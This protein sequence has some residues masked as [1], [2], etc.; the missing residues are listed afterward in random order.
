MIQK[1]VQLEYTSF[2]NHYNRNRLFKFSAYRVFVKGFIMTLPLF[3]L[4]ISTPVGGVTLDR[5]FLFSS[6]LLMILSAFNTSVKRN[7]ISFTLFVLLMFVMINRLF[8]ISVLTPKFLLFIT[9]ILSF[10]VTFKA[11]LKGIDLGRAINISF[12]IFSSISIYSLWHFFTAGY[13]PS[14]FAFLDSISFI[15]PVNYDHMET[16]NQSYI[17][18]R[19]SLPYPTPP[20]LS[21]VMA[22]YSLYY[23]SRVLS[24]KGRFD[25]IYLFTGVIIMLTTISRSGIIPFTMVSFLFYILYVRKNIFVKYYKIVFFFM[26][27]VIFLRYF[28]EDLFYTLYQR[29]FGLSTKEF[30]AGHLDARE[31]GINLFLSGSIG[32]MLFGI[33]IGNFPGL[34][35]HMSL[36]TLLVEIGLIGAILFGWIFSQRFFS[37]LRFYRKYKNHATNN[38]IELMMVMLVFLGMLLYE[39]TY[40]FPLYMFMGLTCGNSLVER[41]ILKQMK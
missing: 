32:Q 13:V 9:S 23:L 11:T 15:R 3:F 17:F 41:R 28:N 27:I 33:G 29:L 20:Q 30:T 6:F 1:Q 21:I 24:K 25:L 14:K 5:F 4:S 36:L 34:H 8:S 26:L 12:I 35:A 40:I 7:L 2:Q 31:F 19:I 38:L 22:T 10:Y 37:T 18:P 39:F 16:V